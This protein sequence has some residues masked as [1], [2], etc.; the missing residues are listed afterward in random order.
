M[1]LALPR[2]PNMLQPIQDGVNR[3]SVT[4]KTFHMVH[5]HNSISDLDRWGWRT[6]GGSCLRLYMSP[7]VSVEDRSDHLGICLQLSCTSGLSCGM[8]NITITTTGEKV[9]SG[10][11]SQL[12]SRTL[13]LTL[14]L[15]LPLTYY[16]F[17]I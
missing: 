5:A 17:S 2:G 3:I 8:R 15:P 4:A 11:A 1:R 10:A 9:A 12:L 16:N 14:R 7:S 13:A 6:R